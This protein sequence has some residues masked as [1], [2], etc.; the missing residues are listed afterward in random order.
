M[1]YSV[2]VG[3]YLPSTTVVCVDSITS[4]VTQLLDRG[5]TQAIDIVTD[6]G[7]FL[8]ILADELREDTPDTDGGGMPVTG[9][10]TASRRSLRHS[11]LASTDSCGPR[12]D[13]IEPP[14]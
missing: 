9:T 4:T 13:A 2:G 6:I 3:N 7:A 5:S 1:L 12:Q 8:P 10:L 11:S 14:M